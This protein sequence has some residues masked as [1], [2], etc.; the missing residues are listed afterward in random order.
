MSNESIIIVGAGHS[1]AKAA[2]ALR[3]H[4]WLGSITLIGEEIHVP[5][6]RPPLSKAVLLGKKTSQQ[7]V[8]FSQAWYDEN[9][10]ELITGEAVT[11]I[12][13]VSRRVIF[14]ERESLGYDRLLLATGSS[15]NRLPADGADLEGVWPLR[16][17]DHATGV[18]RALIPG[19]HL[20]VIGAG[21]I[22]L[23]V[24][25]ASVERGCTVT[26][27][28]AAPQAM[29]RLLPTAAAAALLNEHQTRG[30]GI[31]F[32][33]RVMKLEGTR[34]VSGVT[35][36]SGE[37]MP[38]SG[39]IFGVGVKPR[40]EL[41]EA[42]GLAVDDG[43]LTNAYLQ[44]EDERIFA[45]GDICRYESTLFGQR[46]RLENWRNAEDQAETAAR[47]ML[48]EL[49]A[50]DEVPW[51]WSNQYDVALQV[52]GLPMLGELTLAEEAGETKLF[53]SVRGDGLVRGASAI[54]PVREVSA[55]TR[56]LRSAISLGCAI[57][58]D[59]HRASGVPF[60]RLLEPRR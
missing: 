17:V 3:K 22:G 5:Y 39:V 50:F 18:A 13:R 59:L 19:S 11:G 20:V 37:T 33:A 36:D 28:E 56:K 43:V 58:I 48:G 4:G 34:A 52:V 24:A 21:V 2:A 30:V 15:L 51:F 25:A 45:C 1:G 47:N 42:A 7:C 10:I 40:S 38:C 9:R 8:F 16:T 14:R 31:H 46:L 44:T 6:D 55:F 60:D 49:R 53:L 35:L 23:E 26:V 27:L 32:G 29:G 54:G 41:A 57:D 12:D